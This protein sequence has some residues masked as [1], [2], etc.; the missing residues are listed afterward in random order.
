MSAGHSLGGSCDVPEASIFL[1]RRKDITSSQLARIGAN[2]RAQPAEEFL[3]N[4]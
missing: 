4:F 3:P 1:L 2:P